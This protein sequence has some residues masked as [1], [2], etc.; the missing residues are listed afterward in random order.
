MLDFL[1]ANYLWVVI[2]FLI[3]CAVI[4]FVIVQ[5]KGGNQE[6]ELPKVEEGKG[7]ADVVAETAA[8]TT[9]ETVQTINAVEE[10]ATKVMNFESMEEQKVEESVASDVVSN[11][12]V[13]VETTTESTEVMNFEPVG[14]EEKPVQ[15]ETEV[16][17][18]EP[19]AEDSVDTPVDNTVTEENN[20]ENPNNENKEEDIWKF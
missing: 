20:A 18:F 16:I 13:A 14:E 6:T 5:K 1:L 10:P 4:Y 2:A 19:M 7:I 3:A 12:P 17:D 11:E 9:E 8:G 15:Q